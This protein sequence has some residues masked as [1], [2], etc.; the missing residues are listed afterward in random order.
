MKKVLIT[1]SRGFAD[2]LRRAFD[3]CQVRCVSLSQGYDINQVADW[4]LEFINYD[5]VINCAHGGRG[6]VAVLEY[7]FK[8]WQNN[9]SKQIITIGSRVVSYRHY[10]QIDYSNYCSEKQC[11]QL[12]HDNMLSQSLCDMKIFNPGPFESDRVSANKSPKFDPEQL[13]TRVRAWAREP[14]IKRLD[15]WL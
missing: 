14:D 3:D 15:L 12:I 8:Q 11:L 10:N 9:R 1:G 13:A 5:I 7:F 2:S 6:Q 4:G